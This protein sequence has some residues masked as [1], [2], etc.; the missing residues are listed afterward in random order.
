M[1]KKKDG[2]YT[3]KHIVNHIIQNWDDLFFHDMH[4]HSKEKSWIHGWRNDITAYT[5]IELGKEYGYFNKEHLYKMPI[6]L[7]VKFG[8]KSKRDL[9]YELQKALAAV[10]RFKPKVVDG[11]A[12]LAHPAQIGVIADDLSDPYIHDFIIENNIHMWQI[13]IKDNDINTMSLK[14]IDNYA[15]LEEKIV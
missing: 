12:Y 15:Q 4:F 7:E 6:F 5:E 14:Y 3:E 10:Y 8:S 11:K 1:T 9:V 2:S 13:H